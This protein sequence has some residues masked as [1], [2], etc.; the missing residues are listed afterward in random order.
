MAWPKKGSITRTFWKAGNIRTSSTYRSYSLFSLSRNKKRHI[1]I[2][3][4]MHM[5]VK[6]FQLCPILCDLM[7][8]SL[9]GASVHGIL[10]ATILELVFMLSSRGSSQ[11]RDWTQV[12]Y[13]WRHL[14]NPYI[15]MAMQLFPSSCSI[16]ESFTK[17]NP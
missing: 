9:P 1:Y 12:S 16:I 13:V 4:Y 3:I 14:E 5:R 7:D 2:H 6:S 8:C 17:S 15:L 10:Q 11:S